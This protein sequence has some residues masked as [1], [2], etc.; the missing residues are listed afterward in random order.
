MGDKAIRRAIAAVVD[1]DRITTDVYDSTVVP[2]YSLV[3]QGI[4]SHT[5]PFFDMNPKPD[6][7]KAA[8]I[9]KEAGVKTPVSFTL[10]YSPGG[11]AGPE[12]SELRRQ[13]EATGLFEVKVLSKEWTMFKKGFAAGDYDA[14]TIGWAPDFPDPQDFVAPLVGTDNTFHNGFSNPQVDRMISA[15]QQYSRRGEASKDF[16]QVQR[17][18]ADDVPLLPLW[19]RKE[20]VLAQEDITGS[21][22]LTDGTGLFRLWELDRT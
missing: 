17:I 3:P 9:L 11:A 4:T 20:Y 8:D 21:Q 13:L 7:D 10:A 18:V 1:R 19:Q 22:Y 6:V 14:Y 5:T 12:A 15:T 16:Q 2:L